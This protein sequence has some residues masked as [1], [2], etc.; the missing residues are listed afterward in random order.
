[1]PNVLVTEDRTKSE[2]D[3][4]R[5]GGPAAVAT[6]F[7]SYRPQFERMVGFRLDRRLYGRVDPADILQEA[8]VEIDRRLEQFLENPEVSFFVWARGVAWQVLLTTH[9]N[10]LDAQKRD[11][12]K[13]LQLASG[14]SND[15]TST[16]IASQLAG[17][18][19]TPSHGVIREEQNGL[20]HGALEQMDPIDREVL[21]LRHFEHLSNTQVS[22]LLGI[23][24]T[25]AS[26]RYVRALKRMKSILDSLDSHE[27]E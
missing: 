22:E 9:R 7:E 20:L 11:A 27:P 8:Y 17:D 3:I 14:E 19:T 26:N 15:L 5:G 4:L 10:H 25:A 13:E 6:L 21:A 16:S 24:K 23:G 2:I 18:F 12:R 1:M